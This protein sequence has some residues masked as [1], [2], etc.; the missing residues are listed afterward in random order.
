MYQTIIG[1]QFDS[2]IVYAA[3]ISRYS[4]NIKLNSINYY[5]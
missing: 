4:I 5:I 2:K 3:T 1:A